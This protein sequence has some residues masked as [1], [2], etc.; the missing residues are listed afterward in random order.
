MPL[1]L[2]TL[3]DF[4]QPEASEARF[5][6]ALESA[7]G[8]DALVLRTQL[9]R[10][11]GLRRDFVAARR[12]LEELEPELSGAGH[13]VRARHALELGRT[14]ASAKHPPE[15]QTDESRVLAR[16]A[17]LRALEV[18]REGRLD[19]IAV[20]ALHMLAFVDTAP[21]DQLRWGQEALAVVEASEQPGAKRWEGS[22]RNNIGVALHQL[23]R[24]DEALPHFERAVV[25]REGG[26]DPGATRVAHW[27]V[28]WTLR[29]LG[30]HEDALAIQLRL[31]RECDEAGEPDPYVFE[32]LEHLHRAL[33]DEAQA[34]RYKERRGGEPG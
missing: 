2:D 34:L 19:G 27:M 32:E 21:P 15:A 7:S 9:A 22:L 29:A 12:L 1:D 10:T 31:E 13:E 8:D 6:T 14:H 30:R 5:R 11:H 3:W 4:A 33:G 25:I 24:F 18:A 28:A 17:F 20:D 23:G 16:A 26:S